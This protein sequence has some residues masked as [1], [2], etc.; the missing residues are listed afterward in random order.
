MVCSR[1]WG[2][3]QKTSV[4]SLWLTM[5]WRL[6]PASFFQPSLIWEVQHNTHRFMSLPRQP[7]F[8]S[9]FGLSC[10]HWI[11]N[12]PAEL[13]LQGNVLTKLPDVVA[14]M[15]HLTS[16]SLANNSFSIFPDK[17]TE[18]ATLE[19]INLEG[20]HITGNIRLWKQK[21]LFYMANFKLFFFFCPFPHR[22][23]CG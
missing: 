3:S 1:S 11:L 23:T 17:L 22:H 21:L 15:Q 10:W 18:I 6:F 16:I 12:Y 19:R 9:A 5:R 8:L 7:S 20:N 13:D 14:E 4:L 2:V